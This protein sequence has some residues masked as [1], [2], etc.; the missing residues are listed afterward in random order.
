VPSR[1]IGTWRPPEDDEEVV[2]V[3]AIVVLHVSR[4]SESWVEAVEVP[5]SCS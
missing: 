5:L 4:D 2:A 1:G 3:S